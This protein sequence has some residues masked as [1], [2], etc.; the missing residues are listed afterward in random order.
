MAEALLNS[1]RPERT[2]YDILLTMDA[3]RLDYRTRRKTPFCISRHFGY[4]AR[5]RM[6]IP[7]QRP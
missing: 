2:F 5:R 4:S 6:F 1:F 3:S 7:L